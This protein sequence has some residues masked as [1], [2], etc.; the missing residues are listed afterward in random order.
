MSSLAE[1]FIRRLVAEIDTYLGTLRFPGAVEV[2][3]GLAQ[4][5]HGPFL[6]R[7]VRETT[8]PLELDRA[9][10]LLS[11]D[12][13]VPLAQAIAQASQ[14]LHWITYDRYPPEEIG[15]KFANSHSYCSI[16]GEGSPIE[17]KDFDLGL[18][19][20]KPHTLYRD[21]QHL[22][23]EL[24]APLT[25]PHGWRFGKDQPLVWKAAH[26]P[27]WNGP[28]QHHA[29]KTGSNPFLCIYGWTQDVSHAATVIGCDD[30]KTLERETPRT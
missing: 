5:Q 27:V 15:E 4:W 12:G 3:T 21:H 9:L 30:W 10:T 7:A 14:H 25:G 18:F 22:A 16:V 23:P 24:Y 17:A 29:T 1:P 11:D 26:Q 13:H 28:N 20:I 6:Q 19:I 2:R 8:L